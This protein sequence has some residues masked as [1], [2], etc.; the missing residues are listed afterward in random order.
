VELENIA[1]SEVTQAQEDK[2]L[3]FSLRQIRA[4]NFYLCVFLWE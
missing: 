1:L 2:E 4:S 3:L